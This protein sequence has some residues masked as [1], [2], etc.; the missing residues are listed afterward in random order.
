[1]A[2]ALAGALISGVGMYAIGTHAQDRFATMPAAVP[3]YSLAAPQA[4]LAQ[5]VAK[6]GYT[7]QPTNYVPHPVLQRT[8]VA[9]PPTVYRQ[10]ASGPRVDTWHRSTAQTAL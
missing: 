9:S 4:P 10:G 2:A 6:V 1:M 3:G 7:A 5:P 8:V